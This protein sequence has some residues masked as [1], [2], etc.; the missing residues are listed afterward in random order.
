MINQQKKYLSSFNKILAQHIK[1]IYL[2][3]SHISQRNICRSLCG[4]AELFD[5]FWLVDI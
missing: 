3:E 4:A 5:V 2:D 1:S